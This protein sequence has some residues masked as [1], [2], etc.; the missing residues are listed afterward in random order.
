MWKT[1]EQMGLSQNEINTIVE[2]LWFEKYKN[3]NRKCPD[4]GVGT[5]KIHHHNCDIPICPEC[6]VQAI[7]C[8]EHTNNIIWDGLTPNTKECY[9][10]KWI[11]YWEGDGSHYSEVMRMSYW[12]FDYNKAAVEL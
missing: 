5:G 3:S 4:C 1:V 8:D 7:Q 10:N 9:V 2:G 6:G 11:I 12:S